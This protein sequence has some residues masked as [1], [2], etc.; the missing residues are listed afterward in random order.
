MKK[1][2]LHIGHEKTGSSAIQSFL[3]VNADQL[4]RLGLIFPMDEET[5][6]S[7]EG[8]ISSGNYKILLN[9]TIEFPA[10]KTI[11]FSGEHL[12]F[13]LLDEDVFS[14]KVIKK[15]DR[16]T[17]I[18][19]TRNIMEFLHSYFDQSI[20]RGG[21]TDTIDNFLLH[22]N[23]KIHE[24]IFDWIKM[25][26]KYDF[27]LVIKNYSNYKKNILDSF[28]DLL[29]HYTSKEIPPIDKFKMPNRIKVNRSL[30]NIERQ[31]IIVLNNLHPRFASKISDLWVEEFPNRKSEITK[32]QI[33]T[34]EI[35]YKHYEPLIIKLNKILDLQEKIKFGNADEFVTIYESNELSI[36]QK[37]ALNNLF[38][39]N[40]INFE[41]CSN[42]VDTIRDIAL[43]IENDKKNLNI[44]DAYELMKIAHR[45]R[46]KGPLIKQKLEEWHDVVD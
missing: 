11:I 43:K 2:I 15:I 29:K 19:Y 9:E 16:L 35:L 17:V 1:M 37:D 28:L 31:N 5:D 34:F 24:L 21:N 30:D 8:R 39:S 26:K 7:K 20:K 40:F 32:V 44:K 42:F 10:D 13:E 36:N 33:E 46:Q 41:D 25:S 6:Y 4:M 23:N 18:L 3:S 38:L 22:S 14:K 12:F 45:F 27:K